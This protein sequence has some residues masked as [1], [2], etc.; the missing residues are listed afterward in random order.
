MILLE[1][2]S[3]GVQ[4]PFTATV[5]EQAKNLINMHY[6]EHSD[7]IYQILGVELSQAFG[8]IMAAMGQFEMDMR[9]VEAKNML[10]HIM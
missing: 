3:M 4:T 10:V 8:E 2:G 1:I 7:A 9:N 6:G 5:F